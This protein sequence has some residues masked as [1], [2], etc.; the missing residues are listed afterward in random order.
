M[1]EF[2]K[3]IGTVSGDKLERQGPPVGRSLSQPAA[4]GASFCRQ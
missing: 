4:L 2:V 1:V 3:G